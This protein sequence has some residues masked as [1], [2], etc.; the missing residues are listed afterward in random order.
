MTREHEQA[1]RVV[2]RLCGVCPGAVL[3]YS[4]KGGLRSE[5]PRRQTKLSSVFK[6]M[7]EDAHSLGVKDWSLI[8]PSL[9]Q[10]SRSCPSLI[11][12]ST[13]SLFCSSFNL[14]CCGYDAPSKRCMVLSDPDLL[15]SPF[16]LESKLDCQH[17]EG[18]ET[19]LWQ[20]KTKGPRAVTQFVRRQAE[21]EQIDVLFITQSEIGDPQVVCSLRP[22]RWQRYLAPTT[23]RFG[24]DSDASRTGLS[25]WRLHPTSSHPTHLIRAHFPRFEC[26]PTHSS[27]TNLTLIIHSTGC[28]SA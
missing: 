16:V 25:G 7:F 1:D 19:F 13:R 14:A 21:A 2:E 9:D 11:W 24:P 23:R 26:A 20:T 10:V 6:T 28:H 17:V 12:H 18:L 4:L 8:R 5:L 3:Q 15:F 22:A 27:P